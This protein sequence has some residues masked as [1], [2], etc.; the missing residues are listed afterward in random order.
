MSSELVWL[1]ELPHDCH[2]DTL[3][4]LSEKI[5][6]CKAAVYWR[7]AGAVTPTRVHGEI[8]YAL[9]YQKPVLLASEDGEF[10]EDEFWLRASCS[11]CRLV[12]REQAGA[13]AQAVG[14]HMLGERLILAFPSEVLD[15]IAKHQSPIEL[16]LGLHVVSR[17]D[18]QMDVFFQKDFQIGGKTYRADI[19]ISDNDM[20]AHVVLE[21][22]GHDFHERTKE[23][24]ARD[25]SRDRAMTAAGITVLR[26][27]GSEIWRDPMRC[28]SEA[29][30]VATKKLERRTSEDD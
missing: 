17:C 14:E 23:Q 7:P 28:A 6:A 12:T 30:Q 16:R 18:M 24:A 21:A 11:F 15:L 4:D 5:R 25:R 19:S 10:P 27:T 13:I 9:R 29:Y 1:G 20:G 8:A 3:M 2:R 22:D 26:F